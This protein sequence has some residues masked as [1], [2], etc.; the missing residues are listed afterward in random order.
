[1]RTFGESIEL[2]IQRIA[3]FF[4][5]LV[6]TRR[7]GELLVRQLFEEVTRLTVSTSIAAVALRTRE[8]GKIEVFLTRRGPNEEY[9]GLFHTPETIIRPGHDRTDAF[10]R[11]MHKEFRVRISSW[12]FADDRFFQE[13]RGWFHILLYLINLADDPPPG[14]GIWCPVNN[15][16]EAIVDHHRDWVIQR[17]VRAYL[18]QQKG[19]P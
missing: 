17:A 16:P 7:K 14:V 13:R 18:A 12:E 8:D 2:I 11:L 15:L 9:A 1:M 10:R 5:S 19:S 6:R 4:L 3:A